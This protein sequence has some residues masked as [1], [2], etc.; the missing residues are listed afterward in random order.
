MAAIEN[1]TY[2]TIAIRRD[3]GKWYPEF[4]DY[5]REVVADE[6]ADILHGAEVT[7][8]NVKIIRSNHAQADIDAAIAKL[9]NTN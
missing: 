9:N 1:K 3:D 4:G 7:A 6:R 2:Y 8:K 5:D